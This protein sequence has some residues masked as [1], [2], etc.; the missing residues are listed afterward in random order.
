M[1]Q[2]KN[3]EIELPGVVDSFRKKVNT[4]LKA[5]FFLLTDSSS[6]VL[7]TQY[8]VVQ[9]SLQ[10]FQNSRANSANITEF[11]ALISQN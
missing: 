6:I 8:F 1:L 10:G 3:K 5:A 2:A 9:C 7:S 11:K 4:K